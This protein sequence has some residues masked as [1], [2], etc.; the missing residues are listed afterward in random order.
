[1]VPWGR[2]AKNVYAGVT[3]KL[4]KNC[5]HAAVRSVHIVYW[6]SASPSTSKV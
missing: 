5:A 2:G 1:M 4:T 3:R 6:Q